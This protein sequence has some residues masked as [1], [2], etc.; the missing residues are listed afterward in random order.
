MMRCVPKLFPKP[1]NSTK[2]FDCQCYICHQNLPRV[3]ADGN[4]ADDGSGRRNK[5]VGSRKG[6]GN[7][8]NGNDST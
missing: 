5:V 6:G 2:T 3:F 7:A 1:T 8:I 4:I